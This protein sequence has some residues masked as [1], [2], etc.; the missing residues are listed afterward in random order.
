MANFNT[1]QWNDQKH[2]DYMTPRHAWEDIKDFIP[3]GK[4]IWECFYGDATSGQFLRDLGHEVIHED[5]DFFTNDVGEVLV[6]NPPYSITEKVLE[7]LREIDKPFIMLMPC[8]KMNTQYF[9]RLFKDDIQI[10]VPKKRI[11]FKK[12]IFGLVPD[13]WRN[14]CNFDTFY[15]CYKMNLPKDIMWL[16]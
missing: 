10:I 14:A 4:V 12:L 6:S 7:R 8:S 9:R 13:N 2:N 16:N 3:A 1:P 5:I 15:Y 11:H